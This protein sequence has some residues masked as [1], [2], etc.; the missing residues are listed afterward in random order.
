MMEKL[1]V[2]QAYTGAKIIQTLPFLLPTNHPKS[3]VGYNQ[4][5]QI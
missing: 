5:Y 3:T 4:Y 2:K 1:I